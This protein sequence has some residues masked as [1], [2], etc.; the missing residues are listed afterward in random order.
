MSD[1]GSG[2]NLTAREFKPHSGLPV[3]ST[4]P[5]SDPLSP[6]LFAPPL[7]IT[8]LSALKIEEMPVIITTKH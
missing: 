7:N 1:F 2:C 6:S 8:M 5:T 4:Q 3:V